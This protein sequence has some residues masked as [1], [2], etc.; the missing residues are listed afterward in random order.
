MKNIPESDWKKLHSLQKD[1]LNLACERILK[2]ISGL[3]SQSKG[4]AHET[5]LN[6][7]DVMTEEDR[8]LS[9][10]FDDV[11]RSNAVFKLAQLKRNRIISD[12]KFEEFSTETK[13]LVNAINE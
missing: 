1:L 12:E 5:Y 13:H 10:M 6:I 8:E 2:K 11:K 9:A 4:N 3:M 7:W